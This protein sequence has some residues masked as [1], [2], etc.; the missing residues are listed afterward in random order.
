MLKRLF[1][2][3]PVQVALGRVFAGYLALV[4]RTSRVAILPADGY[5]VAESAMPVIVAM[6]HGQHLM[7]PLIKR[8]QDKVSVLI[9]RHGDGELN[10][11]AAAAL[12]FGL[13]R[14][15]GAQ[16]AD[17]IRKRGGVKAL[18]AMITALEAGE[19]IAL[20]A[21]V[22][23]ISRVCGQG[24]V[25]LA[26]TSGRPIIPIAVC[27]RPRIDFSSW[28][29]ASLGLPFGR[30]A[31]VIGTPIVV[32]RGDASRREAARQAVEAALD[33]AHEQGYRYLGAVDPGAGRAEVLAARES[34]R[35]VAFSGGA[36]A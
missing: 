17:Q 10:A 23:K 28:D 18:R 25:V 14:G 7:T 8:P 2:S 4:R 13:I 5:D 27:C 16:R 21:D 20:T 35:S 12:G 1:R 31:I 19:S 15:S 11:I 30:A 22:P 36:E 9:S 33:A 6:W 24:I 32:P 3:R 29:A 34:A 26:E